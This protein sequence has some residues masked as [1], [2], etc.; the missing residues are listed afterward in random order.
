[1]EAFDSGS[2]LHITKGRFLS[3]SSATEQLKQKKNKNKEFKSH[4]DSETR[5]ET[6]IKYE[7]VLQWVEH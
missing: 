3:A 7:S 1:M 6:A 4:A 2:H 5:F